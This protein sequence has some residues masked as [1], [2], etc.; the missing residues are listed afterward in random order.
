MSAPEDFDDRE[1]ETKALDEDDIA[2]LKTYV[3]VV[4]SSHLVQRLQQRRQACV[5]RCA[6]EYATTTTGRGAVHDCHQDGAGGH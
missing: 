6:N 2:M 3:C 5:L 1:P 4:F